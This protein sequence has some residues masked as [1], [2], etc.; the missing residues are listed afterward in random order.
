MVAGLVDQQAAGLLGQA[1]PAAEVVGAV[2]GVEQPVEADR[3]D[4]A[5]RALAKEVGDLLVDRVV[6]VVEGDRDRSGRLPLGFED[7]GG[8]L[9]GRGQGFSQ[10][11]L[12]SLASAARMYSWW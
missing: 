7:G 10:M 8:V 12:Q 5:D 4:L 3:D 6:A 2:A 11:T 9:T 1:V